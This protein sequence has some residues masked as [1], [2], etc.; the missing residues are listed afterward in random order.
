LY[1]KI[2]SKV[3]EINNKQKHQG[4]HIK[5]I[6]EDKKRK[7]KKILQETLHSAL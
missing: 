4:T 3:I 7:Q 6:Y 2:K 5:I 1:K